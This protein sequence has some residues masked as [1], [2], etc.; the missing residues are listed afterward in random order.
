MITR[1]SVLLGGLVLA[2]AGTS[3]LGARATAVLLTYRRRDE[4]WA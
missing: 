2:G 1:R 4:Y 3:L